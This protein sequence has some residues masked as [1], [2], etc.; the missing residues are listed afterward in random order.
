MKIR[1]VLAIAAIVLLLTSVI[2]SP[3][4]AGQEYEDPRPWSVDPF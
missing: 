2:I 1:K 3:V 4:F